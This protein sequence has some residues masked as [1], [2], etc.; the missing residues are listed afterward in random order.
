VIAISAPVLGELEEQLVVDVLRSGRL[1]KGPMVD[2]FEDA[3]RAV[4]QARIAIAVSSGTSA[5]IAALLAHGIGPG[6]E[7][8]TSPFTFVATINAVLYVGATPRFVDIGDDDFNIDPSL[9]EAAIGPAT[10]AILP[11]HLYGSP[12]DMTALRKVIDG[13]DIVVIEDG[14]QALGAAVANRPV[15][16][17][18]TCCFS[19][20]ATKNV[21]T[22]EGGVVTTDDCEVASA[23]RMLI[24]QGQCATYDY[25]RVGFNFRMTEMQAALGVAQMTRL[26]QLIDARRANA[27][28]LA[29]GLDDVLGLVLPTEPAGCRHAFHQFTV[30]VT[31]AAR[32][33]RD[34][35]QAHLERAGVQSRVYYPRPVYDYDCF[36]RD[37]RVGT[38]SMPHASRAAAEVLSLPVHPRLTAHD[39][40]IIVDATRAALG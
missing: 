6:D 28:A 35:L 4:S 12:V 21:T 10:R 25:A 5:L 16:S 7:V 20:Y 17:Q 34:E 36:R 31:E 38:P 22:G 19:F 24:D 27:R 14:A 3:V 33:T 32:A 15:G 37:P 13:R 26:P 40:E 39:L 2:G 11:V 9:L 23:I 8:I 30:R 18:G 1:V 29:A